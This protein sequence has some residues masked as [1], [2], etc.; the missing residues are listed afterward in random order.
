MARAF[1]NHRSAA[2]HVLL[3][4]L[5]IPPESI[6][7]S[8]GVSSSPSRGPYARRRADTHKAVTLRRRL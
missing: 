2:L 6:C 3:P 7:C 5:P 8:L 4:H 1:T